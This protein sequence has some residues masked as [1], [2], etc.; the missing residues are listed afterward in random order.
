MGVEMARRIEEGLGPRQRTGNDLDESVLL[1]LHRD[2]RD[3]QGWVRVS[4][5]DPSLCYLSSG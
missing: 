4:A 5:P 2:E 3:N 1:G